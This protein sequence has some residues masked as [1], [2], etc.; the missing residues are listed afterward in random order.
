MSDEMEFDSEKYRKYK[1]MYELEE[2]A[3]RDKVRK[4]L[5]EFQGRVRD[6]VEKFGEDKAAQMMSRMRREIS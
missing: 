6:Y 2:R 1:E 3:E 4:A 5:D